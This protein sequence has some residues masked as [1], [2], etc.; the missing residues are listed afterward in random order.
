MG[1]RNREH[2]SALMTEKES[3][4]VLRE[5]HVG[6]RHS[7]CVGRRSQLMDRASVELGRRAS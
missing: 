5:R 1:E 4:D 3:R 6:C 7:A 2:G